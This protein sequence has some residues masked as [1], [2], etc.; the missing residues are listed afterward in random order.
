[1]LLYICIYRDLGSSIFV[2]FL[3]LSH[4]ELPIY[5]LDHF[6]SGKLRDLEVT[7]FRI[8]P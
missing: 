8:P 1:M 3:V 7:I 6:D 5:G 4:L 2:M